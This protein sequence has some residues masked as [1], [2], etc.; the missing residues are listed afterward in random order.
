MV[1]IVLFAV[2]VGRPYPNMYLKKETFRTEAK[3]KFESEDSPAITGYRVEDKYRIQEF[4][5]PMGPT[6]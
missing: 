3:I 1:F 5:G 2:L 6:F 4:Q